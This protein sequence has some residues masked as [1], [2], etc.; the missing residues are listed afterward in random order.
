LYVTYK[1]WADTTLAITVHWID[2]KF[3]L[4]DSVLAFHAL[5]GSHTGEN[6]SNYVFDTLVDFDLCEKLFCVTTDNASNNKTMIKQLFESIYVRT[7]VQHDE[8]NQ[9]IPCF[10]HVI[11]LV[12]G[13]FLKNLKFI[14]EDGDDGEDE[15]MRHRIQDGNEKDFALTMLKICEISKVLYPVTYK[16][17]FL[18]R[19]NADVRYIHVY[20]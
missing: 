20:S 1:P 3:Q 12:V 11:N 2:A 4:H 15:V 10:A 16:S 13:A 17:A 5:E 8:K 7:G 18:R 19:R 6:L 14:A 9:H